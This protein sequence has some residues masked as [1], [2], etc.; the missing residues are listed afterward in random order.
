M[1]L[2][3][4]AEW[5]RKTLETHDKGRNLVE[6]L[7]RLARYFYSQGC[8]KK[9]IKKRLVSFLTVAAPNIVIVKWDKLLDRL[10]NN[11]SKYPIV[12]IDYIP[13]SKKELSVVDDL[14]GRQIRRLAFTLLA[15]AKFYNTINKEN[16]DWVATPDSEIM[17]MANLVVSVT[18][19]SG[20]YR[21]MR[22]MGLL[23]FSLKVDN[24]N[25]QVLF[26]DKE[27]DLTVDENIAMRV[28]R[29]ENLGNQYEMYRGMP[30]FVCQSCGLVVRRNSN[31]Q[32][33]CKECAAN[34]RMRR[35]IDHMMSMKG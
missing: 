25:V 8:T 12:N 24:L 32:K 7:N 5:A 13:F 9:E 14:D 11:A 22:D 35:S 21:R 26:V 15:I 2:L 27:T 19:A 29:Y 23:N 31:A 20:F 17:R 6:T 28:T 18:R 4:E 16:N 34:V 3:N 1:I 10:V 30:F 33:Y